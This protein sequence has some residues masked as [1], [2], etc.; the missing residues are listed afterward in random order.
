MS[1]RFLLFMVVMAGCAGNPANSAS[2]ASNQNSD[3][4]AYYHSNAYYHSKVYVENARARGIFFV[5]DPVTPRPDGSMP[6]FE[7]VDMLK[8]ATPQM[9]PDMR[10]ALKRVTSEI[11]PRYR[12]DLRFTFPSIRPRQFFAVFLRQDTQ[13]HILNLCNSYPSWKCKHRCSAEIDFNSHVLAV[14]EFRDASCMDNTPYW[15]Q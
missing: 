5:S 10:Q 2:R 8:H 12:K 14:M 13:G 6:V 4:M 3:P 9:S 1:A 7:M 15:T 11:R